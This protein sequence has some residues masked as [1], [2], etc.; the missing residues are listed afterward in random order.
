MNEETPSKPSGLII[1]ARDM[2]GKVITRL[3][4]TRSRAVMTAMRISTS[5]LILKEGSRTC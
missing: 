3:T 4:C 2:T 1:I 5:V